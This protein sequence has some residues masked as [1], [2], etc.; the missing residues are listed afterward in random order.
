MYP[1][2]FDTSMKCLD[3]G[4]PLAG[5]SVLLLLFAVF[6]LATVDP[7]TMS[8]DAGGTLTFWI[9]LESN[10]N[11][12]P[13]QSHSLNSTIRTWSVENG[14]KLSEGSERKKSGI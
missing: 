5:F 7:D 1:Y 12:R 4:F 3:A 6:S 9:A 11:R 2:P 10:S 14:N 13:V 8:L